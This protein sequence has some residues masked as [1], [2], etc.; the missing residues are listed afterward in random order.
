MSSTPKY[1]TENRIIREQAVLTALRDRVAAPWWGT[2]AALL[3]VLQM[4]APFNQAPSTPRGLSNVLEALEQDGRLPG[5][6]IRRW[7]TNN[8]RVVALVPPGW[9]WDDVGRRW[10]RDG[11]PV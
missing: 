11:V 5:W 8:A 6:E 1:E 4:A 7:R 2:H 10:I 3:E 9:K